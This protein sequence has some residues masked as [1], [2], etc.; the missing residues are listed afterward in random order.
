[1]R[2]ILLQRFRELVEP[3]TVGIVIKKPSNGM[4]CNRVGKICVRL[5]NGSVINC[6]IGV[7]IACD[8]DGPTWKQSG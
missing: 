6:E 2:L 4:N 1:M 7:I 5:S 3:I 8:N